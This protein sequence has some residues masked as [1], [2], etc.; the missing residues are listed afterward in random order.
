MELNAHIH[1]S[2]G[3]SNAHISLA[4]REMSIN[5]WMHK[6]YATLPGKTA[7]VNQTNELQQHEKEVQWNNVCTLILPKTGETGYR[8]TG[9]RKARIITLGQWLPLGFGRRLRVAGGQ[10]RDFQ[11][12]DK[13]VLSCFFKI[14]LFI[15]LFIFGC[16]GSLLLHTGFSLVAASRGYSSLLC[17]GFSFWWLLLLRSTGSRCM[18]FSSCSTRTQ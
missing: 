10:V 16:T 11:G 18:G 1:Q 12:T 14:N 17:M 13:V 5:S 3:S 6:L 9:H 4:L 7:E 2:V 8:K 15:Y